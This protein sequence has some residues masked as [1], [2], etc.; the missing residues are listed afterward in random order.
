M[1]IYR[2][3]KCLYKTPIWLRVVLALSWYAFIGLLTEL[4]YASST[5]TKQFIEESGAPLYL[6]WI[7]RVSSHMFVFGIESL[8]I[9]SLLNPHLHYNRNSSV[10]TLF[11]IL[12]L[13]IGDEIH[14]SFVPSRFP[15]WEDVLKD[16]IGATLFLWMLFSIRPKLVSIIVQKSK[17]KL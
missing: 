1:P 10:I 16:L 9:Y 11:A 5:N 4:P 13:G 8:L 7:F 15:K 17:A 12:L 3:L 6:N 2:L 14:Q